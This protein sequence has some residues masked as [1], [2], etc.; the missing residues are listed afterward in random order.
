MEPLR[1]GVLGAAR[2][3]ELAIVNPAL[4]TGHRLVAVAARDRSRAE[5][6]AARFGV[7]RVL[8]SYAELLADD[9]VEVIYNPLANALHGPWNL[10]A[11]K[12]GK[13]VLGEK[14]F[15][16]NAEEA[17]E[18]AEA[19]RAAGVSVLEAFH[20]VHHPLMQRLHQLIE[21]GELGELRVVEIHMLMPAPDDTDLRWSYPLAGGAVMDLGCYGLHA[22]RMLARWGGGEPRLVAARADERAGHPGVDEKFE[23]SLEFPNG[24]TGSLRVDMAHDDV[25]FD[26]RVVGAHG[27]A[28]A[29]SFVRPDLDDRLIIN[30][31]GPSREERLGQRSSYTYQLE[32]F[33]AHLRDGVP[34]PIDVEDAVENMRLIDACYRAAGLGPRPRLAQAQ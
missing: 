2:I 18:V 14:P 10:A 8:D 24:A 11:I 23:I 19:A 5:G 6:F 9:E 31:G 30:A 7:E 1:I 20:Y 13:H 27:E 3:S 15:A 28:L 16:S 32:A 25:R 33:A 34:L 29:P 17:A 12:A 26:C 22:Q 21:E 4:N